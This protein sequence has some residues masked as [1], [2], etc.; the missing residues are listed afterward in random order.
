MHVC[1][2]VL[3]LERVKQSQAEVAASVNEICSQI[4]TDWPTESP[5][6]TSAADVLLHTHTNTYIQLIYDCICLNK[7]L[8]NILHPLFLSF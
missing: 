7:K 8:Q 3:I 2:C 1:V 4:F 5:R 6:L